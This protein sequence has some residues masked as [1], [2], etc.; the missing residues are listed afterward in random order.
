MKNINFPKIEL[1]S[2]SLIAIAILSRFIPHPPNFTPLTAIALLSG[3]SFNNKLKSFLIPLIAMF[4]SDVFLGLHSTIWAVYL[5]FSLIVFFGFMLRKS[6]SF[7]KLLVFSSTSSLL[8]Y[9]I[10]NFGV[11][12]SSGMYPLNFEGLIQC[13]TLGLPFY[14]TTTIGMF[15]NAFI[16]D[17]FYSFTLFGT[18]Q[19]AEK[20]LKEASVN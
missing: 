19:F 12:L 17:I 2:L 1:F 4:L 13:Y 6:F 10:T 3:Y 11:W 8:F 7:S 9:L 20:K 18:Y 5:S 16:G 15:G 14:K